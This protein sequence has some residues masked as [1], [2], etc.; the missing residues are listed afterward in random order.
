VGL[1]LFLWDSTIVASMKVEGS[2][3]TKKEIGMLMHV[4]LDERKK[5]LCAQALIFLQALIF[6]SVNIP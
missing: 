5:F 2:W 3:S 6:F 4:S 1:R